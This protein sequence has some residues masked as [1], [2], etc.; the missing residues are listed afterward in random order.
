V[1]DALYHYSGRAHPS[2]HGKVV[3]VVGIV[4]DGTSRPA[5]R[6]VRPD[7]LVHVVPVDSSGSTGTYVVFGMDLARV[8]PVDPDRA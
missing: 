8:D 3:A 2:L 5:T 4:L 7:D 6:E 1:P